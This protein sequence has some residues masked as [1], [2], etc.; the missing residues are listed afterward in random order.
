MSDVHNEIRNRILLL[1]DEKTLVILHIVISQSGG[2]TVTTLETVSKYCNKF[3]YLGKTHA[4]VQD[5]LDEVK[6][7]DVVHIEG[8]SRKCKKLAEY[9]QALKWNINP[10]EFLG[11]RCEIK[12]CEYKNQFIDLENKSWAGVH[13][14][15][16]LINQLVNKDGNKYDVLIIDEDFINSISHESSFT[17]AQLNNLNRLL[18]ETVRDI[19]MTGSTS[20]DHMYF[21]YTKM[22]DL[23]RVLLLI[24]SDTNITNNVSGLN[25]I[26]L[27]AKNLKTDS[28]MRARPNFACLNLRKK[29]YD[30]LYKKLNS[31]DRVPKNFKNI[32]DDVV[33][34]LEMYTK[35]RGVSKKIVIPIGINIYK[36][37]ANEIWINKINT[38][39]PNIPIICLNANG[40][41]KFLRD[42]LGRAVEEFNVN[43]AVKHNIIQITDSNY[44][45]RAMTSNVTRNKG[46]HFIMQNINEWT[47]NGTKKVWV[48]THKRYSTIENEMYKPEAEPP[49]DTRGLSLERY[50][51]SHGVDMSKVG[52]TH[53]QIAI[54]IE[55]ED[56]DNKLIVHAVPEPHPEKYVNKVSMYHEGQEPLSNERIVEPKGSK[57]YGHDYR[58][59]DD[60]YNNAVKR[61]RENQLEHNV[62]RLRQYINLS[63]ECILMTN[64]PINLETKEMTMKEYIKMKG[65]NDESA[66]LK[67]LKLVVKDF[68]ISRE[69]LV[70]KIRR[71]KTVEDLATEKKQGYKVVIDTLLKNDMI[72]STVVEQKYHNKQFFQVTKKGQKYVKNL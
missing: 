69:E 12:N 21:F 52:F 46:W 54:G 28:I 4:L 42:T 34:I 57:Y 40:D 62:G 44:S 9:K 70:K 1:L 60:R 37:K 29:Y 51:I 2:K 27:L 16:P 32:F 18:D 13:S 20:S 36:R 38:E 6:L 49:I 3:I 10:K 26:D 43:I 23:I 59:K 25:F 41:T 14:H 71:W 66:N 64:L 19:P 47:K 33:E 35:Y 11:E 63:A 39:L 72:C 17:S 61:V 30:L 65:W 50:L 8:M 24:L 45:L 31:N 56:L 67:V 68:A 53:H 48:I 55:L 58:Y 5:K 22:K 15:I 7:S